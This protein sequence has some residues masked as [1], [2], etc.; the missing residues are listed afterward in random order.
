MVTTRNMISNDRNTQEGVETNQPDPMTS[1]M[2]IR[3]EMKMLEKKNEEKI[4][5]MKRKN[6]KEIT[7][8]KK[9]I[10]I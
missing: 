4:Q 2:Q 3:R 6:A 8:L 7:T 10:L 1:I 5:G 9:R